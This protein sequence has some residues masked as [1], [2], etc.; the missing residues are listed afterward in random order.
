MKRIFF[1]LWLCGLFSLMG[2]SCQD[3]IHY[4]SFNL[5]EQQN[6]SFHGIYADDQAGTE[7]LYNPERG[8]HLSIAFYVTEP[9]YQNAQNMTAF[10]ENEFHTHAADSVSLIHTY[11]YLTNLVGKDLANN[12]FDLMNLCLQKFRAYGKKAILR[13]A[14]E[15]DFMGRAPVGP[16]EEDILRHAKQLKPFL[17]KNKD[18]IQTVQAGMIGAWGEWHSSVN[19]LE[20][21]PQIQRNILEA[22]CD[23]TPKERYVLV[24]TPTYKNLLD[25]NS[26]EYKRVS[27]H[28][29]FI[30]IK[31]HSWDAGMSEGTPSYK[32][33]VEES[34]YLP[35]NGELPLGFWS[36]NQ[37]PDDPEGGWIIDGIQT[38]RRLFM[39]HFTSLSVTHNY[40][41]G[42]TQDKYSMMYWK[43]SPITE[44]FLQENKMPVSDGYFQKKDGSKV[45][46]NVFDYIRDHL[47]YRIELQDMQITADGTNSIEVSL[48][49]RGFS[50]L[51]NE[52]PVY[53]VLIDSSGN[54]VHQTLTAANVHDWQP[55]NP[56][57]PTRTPLVH[58]I[59]ASLKLPSTLPKGDFK[60]GLW[61]PDGSEN[62]QYK[63]RFAIR[64]ANSDVTWWVSSD[65][66]YGVN[67]LSD[68]LS[69]H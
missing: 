18:V 56:K 46:R 37:D 33:I 27:F 3:K 29:D 11:F 48:I 40:K 63:Y 61:I 52:H 68:K 60:L 54:V 8:F 15:A 65:K 66:K 47:G 36:L 24:R 49:N 39:Q 62:L 31:P 45:E 58:R 34:P 17:E 43:E 20:K 50:T 35:V 25:R 64:C 16:T 2:T 53:F 32:Q 26:E 5:P 13:F 4:L 23:M 59:K 51:F 12:H 14:Y 10:L 7:G 9:H 28:D 6:N 44:E 67:I 69:L 30:V 57:D 21:S 22:V 55:Y 1:L 38:A 42:N 41:E 19:G